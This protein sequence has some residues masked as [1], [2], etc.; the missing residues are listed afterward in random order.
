VKDVLEVYS[1]AQSARLVDDYHEAGGY[2]DTLVAK[3][4]T[5]KRHLPRVVASL[6]Q[7]AG[8]WSARPLFVTRRPVH[9]AFVGQALV[10]F[11]VRGSWQASSL[12]AHCRLPCPDSATKRCGTARPMPLRLEGLEPGR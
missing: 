4:E 6:G 2:V 3:F 12:P 11:V 5:I 1:I 8:G 7:Q 9:A 10:P